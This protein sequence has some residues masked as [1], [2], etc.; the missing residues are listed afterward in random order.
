MPSIDPDASRRL[1]GPDGS[2]M[3]VSDVSPGRTARRVEHGRA[4]T[5]LSRTR[6]R[7]IHRL[8]VGPR[9]GNLRGHERGGC[10]LPRRST[11]RRGRVP[12]EVPALAERG[13]ADGVGFP[14]LRRC[15]DRGELLVEPGTGWRTSRPYSGRP[16]T[17]GEGRPKAIVCDR[18]R[19]AE[20]RQV[21][22]CGQIPTRLYRRD[23]RSGFQGRRRGCPG[24]PTGR[25]RV[26]TCPPRRIPAT[27]RGHGGGSGGRSIRPAMRS[28]GEGLTEGGRRHR[29]RDDAAAAAIL[30]VSAGFRE[31]HA[32]PP[33]RRRGAYIGVVGA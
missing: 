10:L 24:L 13:L 19:E 3:G 17:A 7:A 25:T 16:S 27:H 9:P 26:A 31:W 32:G 30:A 33:V 11:R 15:E 6:H 21:P 2:T 28:S 23:P 8:R 29:A 1:Q 14:L 4:A 22:G 5:G 12:G 20:L 18:W